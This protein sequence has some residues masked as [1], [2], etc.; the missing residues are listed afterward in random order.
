MKE[1]LHAEVVDEVYER[2]WGRVMLGKRTILIVS[3]STFDEPFGTHPFS[4]MCD[5]QAYNEYATSPQR[6]KELNNAIYE[7]MDVIVTLDKKKKA[8][9]DR[10]E[11]FANCMPRGAFG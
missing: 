11:L 1:E 10:V 6:F 2:P 5:E 7:A 3:M 4:T 8:I 9:I